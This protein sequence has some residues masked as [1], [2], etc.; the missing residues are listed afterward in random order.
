MGGIHDIGKY[1]PEFER[2][3]RGENVLVN[4]ST[5]GGKLLI[6]KASVGLEI[7]AEVLAYAILGHHAGL[8]DATKGDSAMN[9]RIEGHSCRV[10]SDI[11]DAL[12][13]DLAAAG[14][15]LVAL[16]RKKNHTGFDLSVATRMAFS[17]LVD[18]DF[19]DTEA[20]YC[21]LAG[22]QPDR[23][24]PEITTRLRVRFDANMAQFT[25]ASD[26]NARRTNILNHVRAQA[27]MPPGLFSL[28]VPTGGGIHAIDNRAG[29]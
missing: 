8:P 19:R 5:A 15:E 3:L 23:D 14:Q 29:M 20:F 18:A 28:T 24:W 1:D 12:Q 7:V 26:L 25:Q 6:D 27:E 11:L 16:T 9:T 21:L 4:H 2:L 13:P 17:F 10:P 22:R